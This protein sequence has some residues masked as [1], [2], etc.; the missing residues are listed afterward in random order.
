M[1][2][3]LFDW[4][5]QQHIHAQLMSMEKEYQWPTVAN[6]ELFPRQRSGAPGFVQRFYYARGAFLAHRVC[7]NLFTCTSTPVY[8]SLYSSHVGVYAYMG[9]G[10]D[11]DCQKRRLDGW[12]VQWCEDRAVAGGSRFCK[13][14]VHKRHF[15]MY[16]G[17]SRALAKMQSDSMAEKW[18]AVQDNPSSSRRWQNTSPWLVFR[19]AGVSPVGHPSSVSTAVPTGALTASTHTHH[20]YT[21]TAPAHTFLQVRGVH[22]R[23]K[24]EPRTLRKLFRRSKRLNKMPFTLKVMHTRTHSIHTQHQHVHVPTQQWDEFRQHDQYFT[25]TPFTPVA[26][27]VTSDAEVVIDF[28]QKLQVTQ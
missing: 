18:R 11:T 17:S 27:S 3:S 1:L 15:C 22:L 24:E 12:H 9:R 16:D 19:H 4:Q 8:L 2:I 28:F 7:D 26:N 20:L 10:V 25:A 6:P 5:T 14:D 23:Q 13:R 21:A